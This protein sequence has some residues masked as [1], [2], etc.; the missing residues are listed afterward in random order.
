MVL[1]LSHHLAGGAGDRPV[2]VSGGFNVSETTTIHVLEALRPVQDSKVAGSIPDT[3][4]D[5]L[6]PDYIPAEDEIPDLSLQMRDYLMQLLG[7]TPDDET[8]A[9]LVKTAR[10]LLDVELPGDYLT[11]RLHLSRMA[12]TFLG[13]LNR[14]APP[15]DPAPAHRQSQRRAAVPVALRRTSAPLPQRPALAP[16]HPRAPGPSP[17]IGRTW[18][19]KPLRHRPGRA[20]TESAAHGLHSAPISHE[21]S[22]SVPAATRAWFT[23]PPRYPRDP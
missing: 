3:L 23:L 8:L 19:S 10:A 14:L 11:V 7:A 4:E 9:N 2:N 20:T 17:G 18:S 13:L 16:P 5:I 15:H 22:P 6:G 21:Q 1:H 12:L